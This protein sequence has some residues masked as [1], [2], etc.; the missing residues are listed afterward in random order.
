MRV[1]RI[2]IAVSIDYREKQTPRATNSVTAMQRIRIV[3]ND[4]NAHEYHC[5]QQT[6]ENAEHKVE[7]EECTRRGATAAATS[8]DPEAAGPRST[9]GCSPSINEAVSRS[10][11]WERV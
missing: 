10:S 11:E 9:C 2:N 4:G 8:E 5:Q 3:G 6:E 7:R 1:L